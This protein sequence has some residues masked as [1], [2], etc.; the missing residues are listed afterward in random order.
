MTTT[1]PR[2]ELW[3]T[4]QKVELLYS[5]YKATGHQALAELC[6][7]KSRDLRSKL[8]PGRE[9]VPDR[10]DEYDQ[11]LVT[12]PYLL[13]REKLEKLCQ[14]FKEAHDAAPELVYSIPTDKLIGWHLQRCKEELSR[15]NPK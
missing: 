7:E 4:I 5:V 2:K 1:H 9:L 13:T 11:L 3:Q 10:R 8:T 12:S 14:L 15:F 6:A